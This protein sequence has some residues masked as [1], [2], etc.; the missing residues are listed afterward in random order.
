MKEDYTFSNMVPWIY[1][2]HI[3]FP[4]YM[5][6]KFSQSRNLGQTLR[7]LIQSID[8]TL[9]NKLVLESDIFSQ[10][11]ISV[12]GL[13]FI[14]SVFPV[15]SFTCLNMLNST[16]SVTEC[17]NNGLF[18]NLTQLF[19][20]NCPNMNSLDI[21]RMMIH[22]SPNLVSIKWDGVSYISFKLV[23]DMIHCLT[24]LEFLQLIGSDLVKGL[25]YL[26]YGNMSQNKTIELSFNSHL[27]AI[28]VDNTCVFFK[29]V[30]N[31]DEITLFTCDRDNNTKYDD[32]TQVALIRDVLTV[33]VQHSPELKG[34]YLLDSREDK[35]SLQNV[36]NAMANLKVLQWRICWKYDPTEVLDCLRNVPASVTQL[37]I[38]YHDFNTHM[39]IAMLQTQL[40]HN[41][42][43]IRVVTDVEIDSE[44]VKMYLGQR[45]LTVAK[46]WSED[47]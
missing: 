21:L 5:I 2:N 29:N 15:M 9:M 42:V 35:L 25:Q 16:A 47:V 7:H 18:G 4:D 27:D 46:E 36:F 6:L 39:L 32:D 30:G 40:S 20:K 38:G 33:V 41:W 17:C 34:L 26:Y 22:C 12:E 45:N 44:T 31:F 11:E 13:L 37:T 1:A 43:N 19:V 10:T 14:L 23:D 28:D 3:S 24:G 8:T